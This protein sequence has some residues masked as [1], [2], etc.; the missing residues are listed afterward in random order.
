[1]TPF[2]QHMRRYHPDSTTARLSRALEEMQNDDVVVH[3]CAAVE[4][5]ARLERR[6]LEETKAHDKTRHILECRERELERIRSN[7][8]SQRVKEQRETFENTFDPLAC[9]ARIMAT[10][11]QQNVD[12][13]MMELADVQKKEE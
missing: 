4:E 7:M 12:K 1:M 2:E 5:I 9:G 8:Y 11:L 10:K 13:E 6:F 3:L